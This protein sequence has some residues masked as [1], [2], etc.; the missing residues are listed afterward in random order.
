M[1]NLFRGECSRQGSPVVDQKGFPV[2]AY[3]YAGEVEQELSVFLHIAIL[4]MHE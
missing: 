4:T 1:T 2:V 3:L